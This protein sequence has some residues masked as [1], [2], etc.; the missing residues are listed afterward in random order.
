MRA[1]HNYH[2]FIPDINLVASFP[3]FRQT[4]EVTIALSFP[5]VG[6]SYFVNLD[7]ALGIWLFNLIA[8]IEEGCLNILGVSSTETL[9]FSGPSPLVAHQGMGCP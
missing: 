2:N 5:M 9:D 3:F 1:L 8:R 7:I 6:F 4:T